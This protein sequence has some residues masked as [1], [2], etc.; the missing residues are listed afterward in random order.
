MTDLRKKID[1]DLSNVPRHLHKTVKDEVG[2]YLVNQVL[3]D[4]E[5]GFSPVAGE[6]QFEKLSKSY[7]ENEKGGRTVANLQLEGDL[8]EAIRFK[9]TTDGIEF[10][11]FLKS[12]HDKADGHNQHSDKAKQ[13]A[14]EKNF[15]K[16]RYIPDDD[17]KFR[18]AIE[19]EIQNIVRS[20]EQTPETN[21]NFT[22]PDDDVETGNRVE[23]SLTNILSDEF[24]EAEI[25]RQLNGE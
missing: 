18:P 6:G 21:V 14:K 17:Q 3:R 10:G 8:K 25:R 11:N 16:R 20:Y 2:E 12:Q 1:L 13:W 24:I 19:R 7:A 22:D 4:V 9:R 23:I 5:R 15:P